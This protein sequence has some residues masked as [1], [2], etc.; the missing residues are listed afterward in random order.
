M[1]G[2]EQTE[3]PSAGWTPGYSPT[4]DKADQSSKRPKM[5]KRLPLPRC[6]P[7]GGM[8]TQL[9]YAI[10]RINRLSRLRIQHSTE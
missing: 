1:A 2:D 10:P 6:T 4:M 7:S 3:L 9:N 5:F 8:K